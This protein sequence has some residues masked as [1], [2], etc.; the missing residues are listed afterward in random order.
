MQKLIAFTC[1]SAAVLTLSMPSSANTLTVKSAPKINNEYIVVFNDDTTAQTIDN[2]RQQINKQNGPSKRGLHQFSLLK[3]FAGHIPKGLLNKLTRNPQV[4][5]IEANRTLSVSDSPQTTPIASAVAAAG[6][7][8]HDRIDQPML[9][10]DGIYAP[11]QTGAGV[12]AYVIDTGIRT[13]HTDFGGRAVWDFTASDIT[14]GNTDGNGHGTHMAGTVGS[15]T[16]GVA[17]GVTLHS[18]KVLNSAGVGT[19][20]GL[21]EGIEYVTN[22]HQSPAVAAIGIYTGF[23][24]ILNDAVAASTAAGVSY[25]VPG[26]DYGQDACSFSPGSDSSVLTVATSASDDAASYSINKGSCIDVF[27]PGLYIKSLWHS[28][29]YANNTISHSPIAAAHVAGAAALIRAGDPT[30]SVAQVK[31]KL[32][33]QSYD[34]TLTNVPAGTVN[35]LLGVATKDTGQTCAPVTAVEHMVQVDTNSSVTISYI[36]NN[37]TPTAGNGSFSQVGNYNSWAY[38][39]NPGFTGIDMIEFSDNHGPHQIRT[40]VGLTG[41]GHTSTLPSNTGFQA[42]IQLKALFESVSIAVWYEK[43]DDNPVDQIYIHPVYAHGSPFGQV[44]GP[45]IQVVSSTKAQSNPRVGVAPDGAFMVV[46]EEDNDVYFQ[47]FDNKWIPFGGKVKVNTETV[48]T[49]NAPDIT[50]LSDG[51][52]VITYHDEQSGY[53]I[54]NLY[55]KDGTVKSQGTQL[56]STGSTP[57]IDTTVIA[58]ADG[59]FLAGTMLENNDWTIARHQ[60]VTQRFNADGKT[61]G[62]MVEVSLLDLHGDSF[63][64]VSL[65][66]LDANRYVVGWDS[67]APTKAMTKSVVARLYNTDGT[68]VGAEQVI[69]EPVVLHQGTIKNLESIRLAKVGVS[70]FM[71]V[72]GSQLEGQF[73]SV[74]ARQF[75][76][77]GTAIGNEVTV[78]TNTAAPYDRPEIATMNNGMLGVTYAQ[79]GS[80]A[81][82]WLTP[83][84]VNN[85]VFKSSPGDNVLIGNDGND[86]MY[87]SGSMSDYSMTFNANGTITI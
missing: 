72:W 1:L 16:Y 32:L 34:N 24:Q 64:Q 13:T 75:N 25:A 67:F 56:F 40:E 10:L 66:E 26:G 63:R 18:V 3:G 55:Y 45:S 36:P 70:D 58:T 29:D 46:F 73:F 23:S 71:A 15:N 47:R 51:T 8:G 76:Y 49:Q 61:E 65:L 78:P 62:A 50:G 83:G 53:A 87:Y 33:G 39:P 82:S 38:S 12:H 54:A 43:N 81:I 27:A 60:V 41:N 77:N 22:N 11:Y 21:I 19:L 28:T 7:W 37:V 14:D 2:F 80:F 85:D 48:G 30:C 31:D 59:G 20:A 74:A 84:T 5:S 42:G 44:Y 17:P 52:Y 57:Q 68:P 69:N 86:E 6:S 9:P 35:K 79:N 4:K